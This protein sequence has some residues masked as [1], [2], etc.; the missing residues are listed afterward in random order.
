MNVYFSGE[1]DRIV[2]EAAATA[3]VVIDEDAGIVIPA[4]QVTELNRL[5]QVVNSIENNCAVVPKGSF[6][7][8][9]LKE[10]IANEA[11]RGLTPDRAFALDQYQH[12]RPVQNPEKVGLM[13]RDES[14]Y[15]HKFLDD[16]SVDF[17]KHSWS[18]TKDC[19][20][21][22][23]NIRNNLGPG[24]FAFHRVNTP[25]FGSIYIGNGVRNNDLPFMV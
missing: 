8:T 25:I 19:T 7:F 2:I 14:V 22:V 5:S 13:Q 4:K 15:N 18:L 17:P 9:P 12:F 11:F 16:V 20:E 24:F 1:H 6:K 23:A 10:T 21:T 3:Q